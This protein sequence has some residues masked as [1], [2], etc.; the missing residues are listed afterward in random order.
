MI[1]EYNPDWGRRISIAFA[2]ILLAVA[3]AEFLFP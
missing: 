3:A 2:A 1:A